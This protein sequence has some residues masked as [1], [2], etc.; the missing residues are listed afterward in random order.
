MQVGTTTAG[1]AVA[2]MAPMLRSATLPCGCGDLRFRND[3]SQE[4]ADRN[5]GGGG[6]SEQ[7]HIALT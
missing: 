4:D 3:G 6:S 2:V 5:R 1:K 7:V